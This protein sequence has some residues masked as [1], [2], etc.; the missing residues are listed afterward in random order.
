MDRLARIGQSSPKCQWLA[1][2]R[3][4]GRHYWVI[5]SDGTDLGCSARR[6]D[7][8]EKVHID[9]VVIAPLLWNIVLVVDGLYWADWL[10]GSAINTLIRVDVEH[11]VT[12]INAV[13]RALIDAGLVLN[14]DTRKGNYVSHL[15][16]QPLSKAFE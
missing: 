9:G 13:N 5:P 4:Q 12:L 16:N 1:G 3:R 14:I 8:L 7:F 2:L 10:A 11:A 15:S 6:A